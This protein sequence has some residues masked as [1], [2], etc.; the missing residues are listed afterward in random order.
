MIALTVLA[1]VVG[2]LLLGLVV[3]STVARRSNRAAGIANEYVTTA[4]IDA[5]PDVVW[6]I[7][8][9]APGYASWNSEIVAI[10]GKFGSG[11]RVSAS[12]KLGSGA[13]RAVPMRITSYQPPRFMEWTGGL[14]LGLFVGRRRFS[15]DP[16][17]AGTEFRMELS[18]TGPLSPLIL[19]SV[20]DRQPEI[21]NFS[22]ALKKRAEMR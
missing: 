14:P 4:T 10:A 17:G 21:D 15:V 11:E 7:L 19:K 16:R 12:V 3:G 6:S 8:S 22:S 1:A 2:V 13:I 18:M 5:E 20:G 9:D